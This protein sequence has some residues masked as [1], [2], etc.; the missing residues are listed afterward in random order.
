MRR[1][2]RPV[3]FY[4][5]RLSKSIEVCPLLFARSV[6]GGVDVDFKPTLKRRGG[7]F[8]FAVSIRVRNS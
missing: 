4:E 1:G 6:G 7:R 3:D 5:Y 2:G 8:S